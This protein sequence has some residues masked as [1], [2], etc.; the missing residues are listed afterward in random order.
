MQQRRN[1]SALAMEL[2]LSC[3]N[4]SICNGT[5]R[6]HVW[7]HPGHYQEDLHYSLW[8]SKGHEW[9]T[10]VPFAQCQSTLP[11]LRHGYFKMW[12]WK[13]MVKAMSVV[14]RPSHS[15]DT[16]ISK[17]DLVNPGQCHGQGQTQWSHLRPRVQSICLLFVSWQ[18]Y[19]CWLRYSKFPIW[20]WKSKVKVTTKTDENLMM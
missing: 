2:H 12:P 9:P 20:P 17:F 14:N 6:R 19:H 5:S 4:P 10:P 3:I 13:S 1:S 18:S 16:A 8:S 11:F 15:W 7:S